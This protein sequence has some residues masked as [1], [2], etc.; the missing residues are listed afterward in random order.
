ME[1]DIIHPP[2]IPP[3]HIYTELQTSAYTSHMHSHKHTFTSRRSQAFYIP[4]M[5][6]LQ[7]WNFRTIYGGYLGTGLEKGCRTGQAT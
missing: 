6:L 4:N 5:R 7:C 3:T 1:R 2:D